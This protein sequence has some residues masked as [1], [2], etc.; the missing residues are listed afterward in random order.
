MDQVDLA[1]WVKDLKKVR[2][3]GY[4]LE[5]VLVVDDS[6]EK[7]ERNYGNHIPV[8]PFEGARDDDELLLLVDYLKQ[9]ESVPNVRCI[10][11]RGW[12]KEV[13]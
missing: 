9:L 13:L 11:K 7:L 2:K 10:D 1:N 8:Q 12:R 4:A 5:H 6:R 3:Q